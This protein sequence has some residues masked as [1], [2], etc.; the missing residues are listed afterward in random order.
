MNEEIFEFRQDFQINKRKNNGASSL[1]LV[2]EIPLGLS[3]QN[4]EFA[5]K[6]W[7]FVLI[8]NIVDETIIGMRL[9]TKSS[10][11]LPRG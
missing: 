10:L 4:L 6:N 2:T 1:E 9:T 3:N 5:I 8:K 7:S 11:M